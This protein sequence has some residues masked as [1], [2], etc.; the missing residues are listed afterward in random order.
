MALMDTIRP[1]DAASA[2][3]ALSL[4]NKVA[5]SQS[6]NVK[7]PTLS[8]LQALLFS[9]LVGGTAR[10][11]TTANITLSGEQTIDGFLTSASLVL[12]KNQTAPAENGLYTS[13]AGAWTRHSSMDTWAEVPGSIIA[14]EVGTAPNADSIW[15][16][17]SDQGGTLGTTAIVFVK[18]FGTNLY[19]PFSSKLSAI[20]AATWAANKLLQLSGTATVAVLDFV[21]GT[22]TP[23]LTSTTNLDGTTAQ[24]C[25]YV[26]LGDR[27]IIWG[28][29]SMDFTASAASTVMGM[30]LP[31]A[32]NFGTTIQ[33]WGVAHA[34]AVVSG[35]AMF[36]DAANDRIT[37]QGISSGTASTVFYFS[38]AYQVI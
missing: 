25:H 6:N 7:W 29:F 14:V 34:L 31:I 22:W 24:V 37:V 9:S 5:V 23:T 27:V 33:A 28:A 12:V 13:G 1:D 16:C 17:T 35:M 26:R 15:F 21:L 3:G 10:C 32:S 2:A 38:G 36:S 18:L 8:A 19:Q 4:A 20:N 11:A 30:S